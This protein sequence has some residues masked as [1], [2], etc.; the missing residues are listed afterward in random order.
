MMTVYVYILTNK[1]YVSL[2]VGVTNDLVRRMY[3]HKQKVRKSFSEKY[4]TTQLVYFESGE[5]I[6]G[7]IVREKQ[8]KNWKRSWKIALIEKVNSLW[9][10]LS[11]D[12]M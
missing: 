5:S 1:R 8:L 11:L 4:Q 7:A 2:Y 9:R 6:E 3:E 12:F 10:D